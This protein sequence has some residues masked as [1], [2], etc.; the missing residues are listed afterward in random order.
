MK[1]KQ[2]DTVY[3]KATID[4]IKNISRGICIDLGHDV[5]YNYCEEHNL[6]TKQEMLEE[7][8][9]PEM[10]KVG[11]TWGLLKGSTEVKIVAVTDD[12]VFYE[13]IDDR[14]TPI[15]GVDLIGLF[16]EEYMRLVDEN[17]N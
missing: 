11:Q 3:L 4:K 9:K 16:L 13:T 2:G 10:P 5:G 17:K 1:F 8:Q 12:N 7:L 6:F 14:R 15:G